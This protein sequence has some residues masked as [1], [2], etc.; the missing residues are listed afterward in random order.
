MRVM[1]ES[2]PNRRR[3]YAA[4]Y[5]AYRS[6]QTLRREGTDF[7]PYS[8]ST[9][10]Y[11]TGT[12]NLMGKVSLDE[13]VCVEV[14]WVGGELEKIGLCEDNDGYIVETEGVHR[15]AEDHGDADMHPGA[16]AA[17]MSQPSRGGGKG[18]GGAGGNAQSTKRAADTPAE[19]LREEADADG[20]EDI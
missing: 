10:F 8:R 3:Q 4:R 5:K 17:A 20:Q 14:T 9:R 16:Q 15:D 7:E 6:L 2:H 19:Q 13:E 11:A 1:A 18:K 12:W